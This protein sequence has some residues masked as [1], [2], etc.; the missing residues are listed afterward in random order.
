MAPPALLAQ[1]GRDMEEVCSGKFHAECIKEQKA[2]KPN[3]NRLWQKALEHPLTQ[4]EAKLESLRAIIAR[5]YGGE[6]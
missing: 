1:V 4:S 5:P 2:G 3:M 6:G